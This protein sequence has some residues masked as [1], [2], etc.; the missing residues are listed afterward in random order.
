MR[1][2]EMIFNPHR[3]DRERMQ[4]LTE[5]ETV[6]QAILR[7]L[8]RTPQRDLADRLGISRGSL[9][10]F[11]AFSEP[12]EATWEALREWNED[13]PEGSTPMASVALALLVGELP[14]AVR[15]GAHTR[16]LATFVEILA[17]ARG[18]DAVP[19]ALADELRLQ[20]SYR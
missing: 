4:H 1:P 11:L 13:R 9:R 5:V 8:R 20:L 15:A 7:E 12:T 2:A 10:K 18:P 16:L 14:A 17:A 3:V 19:R 6:R